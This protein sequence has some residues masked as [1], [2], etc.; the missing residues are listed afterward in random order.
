VFLCAI[1]ALPLL[2]YQ[3]H[4]WD[5]GPKTELCQQHWTTYQWAKY[6]RSFDFG[7]SMPE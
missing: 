3:S 1:G 6:L 2:G 5:K 4:T 7:V